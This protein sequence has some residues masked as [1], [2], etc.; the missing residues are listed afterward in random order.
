MPEP[1]EEISRE[2]L[3]RKIKDSLSWMQGIEF[4]KLKNAYN[5]AY[6]SSYKNGQNTKGQQKLLKRV[7]KLC[8]R[9]NNLIQMGE[10]LQNATAKKSYTELKKMMFKPNIGTIYKELELIKVI[11]ITID[12][13]NRVHNWFEQ[14]EREHIQNIP[15]RSLVPNFRTIQTLYQSFL[16]ILSVFKAYALQVLQD[17]FNVSG[18]MNA[19][20][21]YKRRKKDCLTLLRYE[22]QLKKS[23][24]RMDWLDL[25][26]RPAITEDQPDVIQNLTDLMI[27]IQELC[28]KRWLIFRLNGIYEN[29]VG[30]RNVQP[31]ASATEE[32]R[33]N[34]NQRY[35]NY[36]IWRQKAERVIRELTSSSTTPL[37]M[38]RQTFGKKGKKIKQRKL[39]KLQFPMEGDF[40]SKPLKR[41][42]VPKPRSTMDEFRTLPGTSPYSSS[43]FLSREPFRE[44]DIYAPQF[45]E[46][47]S[48][49]DNIRI[50]PGDSPYPFSGFSDEQSSGESGFYEPQS[51]EE[52]NWRTIPGGARHHSTASAAL[53]AA[54]NEAHDQQLGQANVVNRK[55][56]NLCPATIDLSRPVT[57][58]QR[59][60]KLRQ[61]N[62]IYPQSTNLDPATIG[63]NRSVTRSQRRQRQ[64]TEE[65][66]QQ[67]N[68]F[69][70]L[71]VNERLNNEHSQDF[72][73]SDDSNS[74]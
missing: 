29:M 59:R 21:G 37:E 57:R 26:D 34:I 44:T 18:R 6:R 23:M 41:T 56:T 62:V 67:S 33:I 54:P 64:Q 20:P 43:G 13:V 22:L 55:S 49:R 68:Q 3:V 4:L 17:N 28:K 65:S 36:D 14:H 39:P 61:T 63:L 2:S 27:E 72:D 47:R 5:D 71:L 73:E 8:R 16:I 74:S 38:H 51:D 31:F 60:G 45:D 24:E 35:R 32:N 40:R 25:I 53:G 11:A 1:D 48:P 69:T 52:L 7:Q 19:S 70:D 15:E 50:H 10:N 42:K 46:P 58:S 9:I 12:A 30:K 66:L